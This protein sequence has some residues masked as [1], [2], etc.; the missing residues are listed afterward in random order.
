VA[1]IYQWVDADGVRHYTNL[2]AEVPVA[3]RATMRVVV[4]EQARRLPAESPVA[5]AAE[6]A[7]VA[8]AA[9]EGSGTAE[10]VRVCE[11][12]VDGL[13]RGFEAGQALAAAPADAVEINGPLAMAQATSA[14]A[15]GWVVDWPYE[16]L[17]TTAFDRGR[18]R[19]LTLRMLL[20]E[21][22]AIDRG[23]PY[24]YPE[25]FLPPYQHA[26]IGVGLN[27]FLPRGLPHGAPRHTR[28]VVR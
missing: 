7:P 12:Y 11:A 18:S 2:L 9:R 28:V 23:A 8:E 26:P 25:R 24:V 3:Q 5:V 15:P 14:P 19:H 13:V 17:V 6:P 27:P 16:P 22:F 1:D 21:Q 10:R 20:Q 4:D